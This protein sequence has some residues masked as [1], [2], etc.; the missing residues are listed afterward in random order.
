MM[1]DFK[2]DNRCT[3]CPRQCNSN[4]IY[5][6]YGYCKCDENPLISSIFLHKGE[7]PV[8]SGTKGICNVFFAHCNLR[9]VYCQNYQIS[10]NDQFDKNWITNYDVA[11]E[12]IIRILDS[13]VSILGFVSPTHQVPQMVEI[14]ERIW[15]LG[16]KPT[17]VYNSNGYDSVETLKKLEGIVDVYL[18]DFKYYDNILGKKYSGVNNYFDIASLAL[19]EMYRQKGSTLLLSDEGLAESGI[20]IR[21]LVLPCCAEDSIKVFEYIAEE[22]SPNLHISLMSQYFPTSNVFEN[23]ELN[24]KLSIEEYQKVVQ[25][26]EVLGFKGWIQELS[27]YKFYQ[28]D[29]SK[30]SPFGE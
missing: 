6:E 18:P 24:N 9:C 16:Y 8:I 29:F 25:K 26:V 23:E 27:S 12:Q 30:E 13:G 14:I 5:K 28:P 21:H 2:F 3:F 20:I 15:Q 22:L 17:I 4:R 11:E 10:G 7:E 19:K 1:K